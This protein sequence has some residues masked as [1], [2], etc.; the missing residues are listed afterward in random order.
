MPQWQ[1][2]DGVRWNVYRAIGACLYPILSPTPVKLS[3]RCSHR[4]GLTCG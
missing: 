1:D 2:T 3:N 4:R